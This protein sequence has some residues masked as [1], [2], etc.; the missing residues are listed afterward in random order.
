[1]WSISMDGEP[2]LVN[3]ALSGGVSI[4]PPFPALTFRR[5]L[6]AVSVPPPRIPPPSVPAALPL[7]VLKVTL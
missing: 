2:A 1:M 4:P 6:L 7:T 5:T 3:E